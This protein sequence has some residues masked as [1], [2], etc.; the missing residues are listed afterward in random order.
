MINL[1]EFYTECLEDIEVY[2]EYSPVVLDLLKDDEEV[3]RKEV[4][5]YLL[6]NFTKIYQ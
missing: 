4:I 2:Q 1:E 5:S 3:N 6:T